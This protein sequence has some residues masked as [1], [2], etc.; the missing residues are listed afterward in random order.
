MH[1][2]TTA[3]TAEHFGPMPDSRGD[4]SRRVRE[5]DGGPQANRHEVRRTITRH[6]A[7]PSA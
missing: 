1:T 6:G 4:T 2:G 3:I 5:A 7:N